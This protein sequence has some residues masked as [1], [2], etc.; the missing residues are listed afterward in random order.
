MA[1]K[2]ELE[3]DFQQYMALRAQMRRALQD[4]QYQTG[5]NTA[6]SSFPHVDGMMQFDSRYGKKSQFYSIDTLDFVLKYAPLLFDYGSLDQLE[7]LIKT[8]RRIAK[9]TVANVFEALASARIQMWEAHRLWTLLEKSGHVTVDDLKYEP[10]LR[11]VANSW[12]KMGLIRPAEDSMCQVFVTQLEDKVRI[13]CPS[14]GS[15]GSG[16][17]AKLLEAITC[18]RCQQNVFFVFLT[19]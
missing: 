1:K 2:A 6:V 7:N 15:F 14:C 11:S 10:L 16:T 18:P 9:N 17:K 12:R 4:K 8:H 13:K 5:I 3:I 19:S